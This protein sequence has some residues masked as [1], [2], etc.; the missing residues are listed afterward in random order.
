MGKFQEIKNKKTLSRKSVSQIF[1][2]A[3]LMLFFNL[4]EHARIS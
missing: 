2:A 1:R 4:C 3:F